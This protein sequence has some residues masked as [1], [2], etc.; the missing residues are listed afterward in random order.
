MI[1]FYWN[2]M[3][4]IFINKFILFGIKE[5]KS[6]CVKIYL[7]FGCKCVCFINCSGVIKGIEYIKY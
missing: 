6:I 3:V 5:E 2:C 4:I 1:Y 7:V